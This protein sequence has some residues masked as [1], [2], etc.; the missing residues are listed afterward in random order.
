MA[1]IRKRGPLQ[2]QAFVRRKGYPRQSKTFETRK[3]AEAWARMVEREIETGAWRDSREAESTTLHECL[4][5]YINEVSVHKKGFRQECNKANVIARHP[6]ASMLMANIRGSHIALYRDHRVSEKM[7]PSTIQKELALLSHLFN[8]ARKEWGMESLQNPVALVRKPKISNQ[9]DRRLES[10]EEER[11]LHACNESQNPYLAPLVILALETGQRKGR[12]L[13]M[14]W[15]KVK[16]DKRKI[17]MPDDSPENKKAPVEIPL[18]SRALEIL[19]SLH[20][21]Q[22]SERIINSSDNA[23]KLSFLRARKRAGM[24]DFRFHDL[25]H[26]ATSRFFEKGLNPMEVAAITGHKTLQMLKR[27]THLKAE[28]LAAKLG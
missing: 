19:R 12:L 5:R 11:L 23:L 24:E 4:E 22:S 26:E 17:I 25:R 21:E 6:I 10:G 8:T 2:W 3:N 15:D 20:N 9:R 14:E 13:K 16:F 28:D 27:Y 18:S 1:T 7:S